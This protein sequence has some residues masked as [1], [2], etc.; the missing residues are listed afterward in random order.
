MMILAFLIYLMVRTSSKFLGFVGSTLIIFGIP[1]SICV[2]R[3]LLQV[4]HMG[5]LMLVAYFFVTAVSADAIFVFIETWKNTAKI[6]QDVF[7]NDRGSRM[8]FTIRTTSR[9]LLYTSFTIV[10]GLIANTMCPLMPIRSF[11]ITCAICFLTNFVLMV[12][13]MPSAL[14]IHDEY[15]IGGRKLS[16]CLK[17]PSK[18]APKVEVAK[19]NDIEE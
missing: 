15:V 4:T 8:A 19:E 11:S 17:G 2:T 16:T 5:P 12:T 14:A 3:A 6:H 1:I 9:K 13:I 18:E 10:V 7:K